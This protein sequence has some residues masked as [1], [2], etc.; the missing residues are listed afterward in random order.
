M[1]T[2]PAAP[3]ITPMAD[4]RVVAQFYAAAVRRQQEETQRAAARE[5]L[6]LLIEYGAIVLQ[7]LQVARGG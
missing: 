3:T 1:T 2:A 4:P 6:L 7:R 5:T